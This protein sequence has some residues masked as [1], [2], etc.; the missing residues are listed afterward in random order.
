MK[1]TICLGL[2]AAVVLAAPRPSY[3]LRE[4]TATDL[5]WP[6]DG[7]EGIPTDAAIVLY[8][9][10]SMARLGD[11]TLSLNTAGGAPVT[12]TSTISDMASNYFLIVVTPDAPLLPETLYDVAFFPEGVPGYNITEFHF[13]TG[14]AGSDLGTPPAPEVQYQGLG[15][16]MAKDG[17]WCISSGMEEAGALAVLIDEVG[18][19]NRAVLLEARDHKEAKVYDTMLSGATDLA[20]QLRL[21]GDHYRARFDVDPCGHYCVRAAALD[22][23]G[24]PGPWSEWS[25]SEEI[26]SWVCGDSY[27]PILFGDEIPAGSTASPA[28]QKC[29]DGAPPG[30]WAAEEENN[31]LTDGKD[32]VGGDQGSGGDC[33]AAPT[34][35]ARPTAMLG[36]ALLAVLLFGLGRKRATTCP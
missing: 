32:G 34:S 27:S 1:K 16:L 31:P 33:S 28:T 6:F 21:A 25:C 11:W 30:S 29:I 23:R 4:A 22:H 2:L 17:E 12:Y 14:P 15:V 5:V 36:L 8:G 18:L 10:K 3:A 19:E 35:T 7:M 9:E 13:T 20:H 26:G 24:Q